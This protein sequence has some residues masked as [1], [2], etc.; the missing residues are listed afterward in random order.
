MLTDR[1][2]KRDK[3]N[4]SQLKSHIAKGAAWVIGARL[5]A[6]IFAVANIAVLARLLTPADFGVV[7]AA[8]TALALLTSFTAFEFDAVLVQKESISKGDYNTAFTLNLLF[9]SIVTL[10]AVAFSGYIAK[11]FEDSR[12]HAV[13][14][15]LAFTVL[16]R[17]LLNTGLVEFRR[18]LKFLP[19]FLMEIV[20]SLVAILVTILT[21]YVWRSYWALVAGAVSGST[22]GLILSYVIHPLRPRLSLKRAQSFFNFSK[23]VVLNNFL[24]YMDTRLADAIIAKSLGTVQLGLFRMGSQVAALAT[25]ELAAPVNRVL[26]PGYAKVAGDP[27]ALKRTY[28][29]SFS[30]LVYLGLPAAIGIMAVAQPLVEVLLGSKWT[31]AVPVIKIMALHGALS[32]LSTNDYA[33]YMAKGHPR[34][35]LLLYIPF[36]ILLL[37]LLFFLTDRWGIVGTASSFVIANFAVKPLYF[38]VLLRTLSIT[39]AEFLSVIWRALMGCLVMFITLYFYVDWIETT[40]TPSTLILASSLIIGFLIYMA[41]TGLIWVTTR[42]YISAEAEIY[43]LVFSR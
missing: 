43:N 39:A 6:R 12:I 34:T 9:A 41:T 28:L 4:L 21:A 18:N 20:P 31:H 29:K 36:V 17:G 33:V 3:N 32:I 2:P 16:A 25:T 24:N 42:P 19:E 26:F 13:V 8:W 22:T 1:Y 10:L 35:I 11:F 37:P 30:I 14:A 15:A 27:Q 23:W 40:A 5:L 7:A 38:Y